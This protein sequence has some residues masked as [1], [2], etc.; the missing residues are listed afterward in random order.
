MQVETHLYKLHKGMLSQPSKIFQHLFE[1]PA[2]KADK[3]QTVEKPIVLSGIESD[4]FDHLLSWLY[5]E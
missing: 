5:N 2:D 4:K 1:L 3:G